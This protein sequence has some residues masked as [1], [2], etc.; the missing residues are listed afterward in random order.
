MQDTTTI[1]LDAAPQ[2]RAPAHIS[3]DLL[4]MGAGTLLGVLFGILQVFLIPRLV[5]VRN[6]GY[7]RLF[8]LYASY[9]GLLHIGMA[10]GALLSWVGKPLDFIGR[11]LPT[12]LRFLILQLL[13]FAC[14]GSLIPLWL[15]H[16]APEARFVGVA[17]LGFAV[18]FNLAALFQYA[19]Q[20][21]R[22]FVPVAIA[23]AAPLGLFVALSFVWSRYRQPD[24]RL[25]IGFYFL[26]WIVILAFLWGSVR[27]YLSGT[28]SGTWE[29][30]TR[31]LAIGWPVVLANAALGVVQ[32]A[33]RL[34]LSSAVSIYD[35]AQYSL[36]AS[37]MMVPVTL[38]AAV[39]QVFFPHFA[40]ADKHRHR[41]K[42]GQTSRLI[43]LSWSVLLPYYFFL[44]FF[45]HRFLPRYVSTL[46]LARTLLLGVLFLAAIQILQSN[47]FNLYG[48]QRHFL[49]YSIGAVAVSI[50]LTATAILVFH[51]LWLVAAMQVLALGIW[52]L[53]NACALTS[54][55][56]ESWPQL[57]RVIGAFAWSAISL[58]LAF[59]WSSNC[60]VQ[61]LYY[62]LLTAGPLLLFFGPE[63]RLMGKLF[64]QATEGL[65]SS[66]LITRTPAGD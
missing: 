49:A 57:A 66:W 16:R 47:V 21:G 14:L 64:K 7:W 20:A 55:S 6:Y 59:S 48:K 43:A 62:W 11:D 32:S 36:A 9:A 51:S 18:V 17:A 42:Y 54:L 39:A 13:L 35:F 52:W 58:K 27:P 25:L 4:V 33:D 61:T 28:V 30:G 10:D 38:I 63:I 1:A 34:V 60:A 15:L 5:D 24:F 23:V 65:P 41:E 37:T 44:D 46:P 8:Y 40:A 29:C 22:H 45:V 56:G 12:A 3:R 53:F 50:A 26:S 2:K 31:Y 19:L